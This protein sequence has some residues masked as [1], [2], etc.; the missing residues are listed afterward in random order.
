V[1]RRVC[2]CEAESLMVLLED[3]L[4]VERRRCGKRIEWN[5]VGLVEAR[6]LVFLKASGDRMKLTF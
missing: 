5:N 4:C 6:I 2:L 3:A 1:Y